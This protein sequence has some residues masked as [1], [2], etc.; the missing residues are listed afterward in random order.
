MSRPS[1]PTPAGRGEARWAWAAILALVAAVLAAY[2]NSLHGAFIFDDVTT[3]RD[4][5]EVRQLWPLWRFLA[6]AVSQGLTSS[7]RPLVAL[8][9]ALNYSLGAHQ[10][11]GYHA[12]N[13]AVHLLGTLTLFGLVRRTLMAGDWGVS[14]TRFAFAVAL[15]WVLHPLQTEAVAY[16]VQRAESNL[17]LFYLATLYGFA[18]YAGATGLGRTAWACGTVLACLLGMACK[19]VMVSA[20]LMVLLYDRCF[21]SGSFAESWRRHRAVLLSLASTWALLGYEVVVNGNRGG[22]AGLGARL[23]PWVYFQGQMPA[24]VHYLRLCLW[25]H[26][27]V[28]DYGL[29]LDTR[30]VVVIPSALAVALMLGLIGWALVRRPALGFLGALAVAVLAPTSSLIPVATQVMAEHRM[31]L[32]L[33]AV[34]VALVALAT[35]A[36]SRILPSRPVLRTW[37]SAALLAGLALGAGVFTHRRNRDYRTDEGIWR[38][39]AAAFPGNARSHCNLGYVLSVQ[40]RLPEAMEEFREA[41]R[42]DPGYGDAENNLGAAFF[43]MGNL[44]ESVVHYR[45]ALAIDESIAGAHYNLGGSLVRMGQVEEGMAEFTEALRLDPLSPEAHYDLATA[46][47]T[48]RRQDEAIPQ[49]EE[50]IRIRP[51]YTDAYNNLATAKLETGRVD[52]AVALYQKTLQLDPGS[53]TAHFNLANIL[54]RRSQFAEALAHYH[55]ALALRPGYAK[56]HCNLGSTLVEMGDLQGAVAEYDLA[57]RY[58][59]NLIDARVNRSRVRRYLGLEP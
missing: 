12:F 36:A 24:V 1:I 28:F 54:A 11:E 2:A 16:I 41:L 57:L 4:N 39:A 37:L 20:P 55:S 58:D 8:S 15:L 6:P 23:S 27:L 38:S 3:I 48:L 30:A 53:A 5:P 25:P 17:A 29:H 43:Q 49:F 22:T 46:L 13:I 26:P 33:A 44:P 14:P 10:V 9:L 40:G 45:R 50:A 56:A 32:P 18:R 7:G 34:T 21:V 31:Y 52:E 19:E 42:I 47:A 35:F 51:D 59:P